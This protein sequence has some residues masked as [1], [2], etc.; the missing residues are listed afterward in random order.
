MGESYVDISYLSGLCADA[1]PV[2]VPW[3]A[4]RGAETAYSEKAAYGEQAQGIDAE[5][6]NFDS[7]V[8]GNTPE[9]IRRMNRIYEKYDGLLQFNMSR[10]MAHW[11]IERAGY[12]E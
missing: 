6:G 12:A 10:Y 1:A 5:V 4:E 9:Y 8:D 11:Q 7:R 3:I 2:L